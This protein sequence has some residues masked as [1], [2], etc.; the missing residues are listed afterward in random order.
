MTGG[1]IAPCRLSRPGES[2]RP[3]R[4]R[5]RLPS[6][7]VAAAALAAALAFTGPAAASTIEL[8][9]DVARDPGNIQEFEVRAD[10]TRVVGMRSGAGAQT[11]TARL[12]ADDQ[13]VVAACLPAGVRL[14]LVDAG[15]RTRASA[16]CPNP[17]SGLFELVPAGAELITR[18]DVLTVH[19]T[20]PAL[21]VP[22]ALS[23]VVSNAVE[24]LIQPRLVNETP[25]TSARRAY[26]IR[27]RLAVPPPRAAAGLMVL[28]RR[29][30]GAWRTIVTKRP[31]RFGRFAHGAALT[32]RRTLL[33][34]WFVP[35]DG[36]GWIG[37]EFRITVTRL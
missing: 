35:A 11:F 27:V 29:H 31:D 32:G 37:N 30:R 17:A 25:A 7:P 18:P 9:L 8:S 28:Q 21:P 34:I 23:P 2:S 22:L 6:L 14:D 19:L 4:R 10:G 1:V 3:R 20:V 13:S 24:L 15:G 36:T 26:P 5:R 33:R 12:V 16:T